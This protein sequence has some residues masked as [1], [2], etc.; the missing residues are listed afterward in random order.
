MTRQSTAV[1]MLMGIAHQAP[2]ADDGD[3]SDQDGGGGGGDDD[4]FLFF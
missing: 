2:H 1:M 3:A 4:D